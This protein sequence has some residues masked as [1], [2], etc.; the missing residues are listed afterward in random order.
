MEGQVMQI[1]VKSSARIVQSSL[2]FL[3]VGVEDG[4]YS[5]ELNPINGGGAITFQKYT[6]T[7]EG[8]HYYED[9][10]SFRNGNWYY[11]ASSEG[12]DCDGEHSSSGDYI[13]DGTGWEKQG[14]LRVRD[15][16]AESMGY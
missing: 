9:F 7:E 3:L 6:T 13:W 12:R 1:T 11:T 10:Y 8:Y 16:T 4:I 5:Y 2:A 14:R 15:Y